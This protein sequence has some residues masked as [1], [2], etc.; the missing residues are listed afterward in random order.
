ML[1][2][3]ISIISSM[4][5]AALSTTLATKYIDKN[6]YVKAFALY[7]GGLGLSFVPTF[8]LEIFST[9]QQKQASKVANYKA[10]EDL[11]DYQNFA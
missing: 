7:I 9:K 5:G 6:N 4:I 2:R 11:K 3:P 1:S 8:I 10:V